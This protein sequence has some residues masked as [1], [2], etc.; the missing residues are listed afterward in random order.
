M[1]TASEQE[2]LGKV[3]EGFRRVG[4]TF[5]YLCGL[6]QT[7][8]PQLDR[9]IE[10]MGVFA[11]GRLLINPNF[12][13]GLSEQDLLFVLAHEL[14]HLMLRTHERGE[15]TDPLQFN[16][17]HDYIINDM[18]REA[19][20]PARRRPARLAADAARATN[21]RKATSSITPWKSN[22]FPELRRRSK[23]PIP[24]RSRSRRP[25]R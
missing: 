22:G 4:L 21:P 9:R 13:M 24:S 12:V 25:G 15:G 17:A 2:I 1:K 3:R 6:I 8:Q 7:V 5:P 20:G 19:H 16:F 23:R 14:Y 10:T 11:S 18:L